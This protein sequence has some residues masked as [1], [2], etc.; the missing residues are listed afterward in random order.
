MMPYSLFLSACFRTYVT[1][2]Q[3]G[4]RLAATTRTTANQIAVFCFV[5]TRP[6]PDYTLYREDSF[7]IRFAVMTVEQII[8]IITKRRNAFR[9]SANIGDASDPP[10]ASVSQVA[11]EKADE[12]DSLLN[13][14]KTPKQ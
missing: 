14:I 2:N 3:G 7:V 12:Y 6:I 8:E 5:L 11:W 13:E 9:D 4:Y 1:G 10:C